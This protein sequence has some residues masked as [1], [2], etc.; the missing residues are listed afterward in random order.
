MG[1]N[2]VR[3]RSFPARMMEALRCGRLDTN[4]LHR[5]RSFCDRRAKL[6]PPNPLKLLPPCR[7]E[8]QSTAAYVRHQADM[9]A[10]SSGLTRRID[11]ESIITAASLR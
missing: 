11:D 7:A 4:S 1:G 6:Q 5:H 2:A 3:R 8:T 9:N 10:F